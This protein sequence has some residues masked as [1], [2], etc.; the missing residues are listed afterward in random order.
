MSKWGIVG[1]GFILY[2]MFGV[3]VWCEGFEVVVILGCL[4]E[5]CVEL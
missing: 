1:I 5:M 4:V 2:V 3:I